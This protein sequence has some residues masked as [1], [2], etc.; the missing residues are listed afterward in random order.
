VLAVLAEALCAQPF[1]FGV[2]GGVRTT[3]LL[4]GD[5]GDESKRY[6]V[7]PWVDLRLPFRFSLEVD[8]LYQRSGYSASYANPLEATFTRERDDSWEFPVLAKYHMPVSRLHPF[9]GI[10]MAPRIVSGNLTQSGY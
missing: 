3:D 5:L 2:K 4:T 6:I 10:G 9:A 7:G 1:T 8:A